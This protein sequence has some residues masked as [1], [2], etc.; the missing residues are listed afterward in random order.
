MAF[1]HLVALMMH[2]RE[3]IIHPNHAV[4]NDITSLRR[5]GVSREDTWLDEQ[6]ESLGL[7]SFPA[8]KG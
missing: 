6:L 8:V 7:A 5:R 2:Y 4:W 1:P 3:G